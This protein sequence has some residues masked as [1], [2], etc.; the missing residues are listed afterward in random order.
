MSERSTDATRVGLRALTHGVY[1]L[2]ATDQGQDEYLVVALAMQCSVEPPRLAFSIGLNARILP[3]L[4]GANGGALGI[5]DA[6]QLAAVRRYGTP[7][8]VRHAP[9]NCVRTPAGHAVPPEARYWLEFRIV[10]ETPVGDHQ[11]FVV[12]VSAAGGI[13]AGSVVACEAHESEFV[14]MTLA[15]TGFPY[16]G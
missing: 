5:L 8:G 12:Q 2:T 9:A 10:Q 15:A 11:L 7:G 4:R 1:V 16:A 14:P 3:S 13:E 6:T